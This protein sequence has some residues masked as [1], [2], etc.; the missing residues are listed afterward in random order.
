MENNMS[1]VEKWEL[2]GLLEEAINKEGLSNVLECI[3]VDIVSV[4][5]TQNSEII[6]TAAVLGFPIA[7]RVLRARNFTWQD[8][9]EHTQETV[10][11]T[12]PVTEEDELQV[13]EQVS[14][15]LSTLLDKY[16]NLNVH[17]VKTEFVDG[18]FNIHYL[19]S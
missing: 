8:G 2:S 5:D 19:C 17:G 15:Q 6:K 14:Q 12:T 10:H 1:L 9:G 7:N 13:C 11:V 18:G 4:R 16:A 3:A